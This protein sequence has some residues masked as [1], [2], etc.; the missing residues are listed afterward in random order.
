MAV[1]DSFREYVLEQLGRVIPIKARRMFGGV[2]LYGRGLFFAVIDDDV[3]YFK[4]DETTRPDFEAQGM[5]PFR[6]F[7]PD[8]G[9]LRYFAVPG[10]VL[11]D[12]DRLTVWVGKALAVARTARTSKSRGR[13][14]TRRR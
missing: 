10:D 4:V 3:L 14:R 7:G 9:A 1:S 8:G 6:P 5:Q 2:G 11:D 13:R 12:V